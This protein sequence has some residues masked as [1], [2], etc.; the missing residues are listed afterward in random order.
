MQVLEEHHCDG[1]NSLV[2][3]KLARADRFYSIVNGDEEIGTV[4]ADL[5]AAPEISVMRV[6]ELQDRASTLTQLAE[7]AN[8]TL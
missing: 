5:A 4:L 8:Q 1:N 3:E 7:L 2:K 6:Y